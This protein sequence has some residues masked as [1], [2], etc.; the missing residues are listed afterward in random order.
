MFGRMKKL[1]WPLAIAVSFG[2]AGF[3]SETQAI[4]TTVICTTSAT[5]TTAGLDL[6]A[7]TLR[8]PADDSLG[9][10]HIGIFIM[11]PYSGYINFQG[12]TDLA[13]RG[14]TTLCANSVFNGSP[15]GY[16]GYEQHVP[17]IKSGIN[18][19]KNISASATLPAITKVLIFG[20]SM[21]A[22]MMTFYQN[23]AENGPGVCM[24]PEKIIPCVDT[25]LYNL[26]K[27]DGVMLFDAHL[28]D[29]LATFTYVDPAIHNNECLPR[30]L[31]FD[32][33]SAV[34]GYDTTTNGATYSKDFKKRYTTGQA[35]RNQDLVNEALGLL[36]DEI[37]TTGDPTRLGDDI[38]F[39]VVGSTDARL[40][41]P[42]ISLLKY[43]Q[44]KHILLARD[45]TRPMQII[46]SVRTPS[47]RASN[48]LD[49]VASTTSV[50]VHIWLGAHTL[51]ATPG[52]YTQTPDDITGVDYDSS[53]TTSVTNVKGISVPLV[54]IANTGHYFLRPDEI[55]YDSAKSRDKTIAF[56]E[57][58][59]HGGTPCLSCAHAIDPTITTQAQANAYWGDTFGR[60]MDFYSEWLSAKY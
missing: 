44:Q 36:R 16:Y 20:H 47:G 13:S 5:C 46:Q 26:P 40:W 10:A 57:G 21:G 23:V 6:N 18:Y 1:F 56:E 4:T 43:T 50:N 19:L 8:R 15:N 34:N 17:G 24:G 33:F 11:H 45:G 22:P 25:N 27:A 14:Y 3:S 49:C 12:C 31:R 53:A 28:G 60:T 48:G 59:V 39:A 32:M 54:I 9:R 51:R 37:K 52:R 42:D 38:P 2:F 35:I 41:Q 30:N 58:A 7:A 29:G 55:I